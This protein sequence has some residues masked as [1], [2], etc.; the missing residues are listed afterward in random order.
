MHEGVLI[1]QAPFLENPSAMGLL[2]FTVVNNLVDVDLL[3]K[4]GNA[5]VYRKLS[6]LTKGGGK[7]VIVVNPNATYR[8][9]WIGEESHSAIVVIPSD[10]AIECG[11]LRVGLVDGKFSVTRIPRKANSFSKRAE[12]KGFIGRILKFV[13]FF[14]Y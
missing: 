13:G 1:S 5:G 8:E 7:Y 14:L 10:D 11:E 12:E 9:Y 4:E 2:K 3:L 6:T